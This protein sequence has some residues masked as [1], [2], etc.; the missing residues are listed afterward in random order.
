MLASFFFNCF[1][2]PSWL[3]LQ[4][5]DVCLFILCLLGREEDPEDEPHGHITS[6]VG[7]SLFPIE[8]VIRFYIA[9]KIYFVSLAA[10]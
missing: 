4:F 7:N 9:I 3:C 6:V 10:M 1:H 5:A 2:N 8:C